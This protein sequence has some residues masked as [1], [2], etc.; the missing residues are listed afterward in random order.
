MPFKKY[1]DAIQTYFFQEDKSFF[2]KFFFT[3][4]YL[5]DYI[6]YIFGKFWCKEFIFKFKRVVSELLKCKFKL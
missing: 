3:L 5:D 4:N 1:L 6:L 2:F